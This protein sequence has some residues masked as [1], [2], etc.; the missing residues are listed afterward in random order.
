M[1]WSNYDHMCEL[2]L[3]IV[4]SWSASMIMIQLEDCT[5]RGAMANMD[6]RSTIQKF[7]IG[8]VQSGWSQK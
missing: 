2:T 5:A 3:L 8:I 6:A 7:Y 4:V 1:R